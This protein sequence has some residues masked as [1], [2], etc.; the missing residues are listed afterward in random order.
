[1]ISQ[2]YQP[3]LT[4]TVE[5]KSTW[6]LD[7]EYSMVYPTPKLGVVCLNRAW[8]PGREAWGGSLVIGH[9]DSAEPIAS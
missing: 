9:L 6:E 2:T 4:Q 5:E 7:F 1:M 3:G 8:R